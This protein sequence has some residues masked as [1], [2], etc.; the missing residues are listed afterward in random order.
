ML[1]EAKI[2]E[3]KKLRAYCDA[4]IAAQAVLAEAPPEYQPEVKVDLTA[5][6][7][8]QSNKILA[9]SGDKAA[10]L[11]TLSTEPTVKEG[12]LTKLDVYPSM[13]A[14]L[15]AAAADIR[16]KALDLRKVEAVPKEILK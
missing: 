16:S 12:D 15:L 2:A 7:L 3:L 11:G 8:S 5:W 13:E 14:E 10:L 1:T 9:G 6:K 4:L